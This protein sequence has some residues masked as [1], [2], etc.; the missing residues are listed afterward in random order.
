LVL[1]GQIEGLLPAGRSTLSLRLQSEFSFAVVVTTISV[2]AAD[3]PGCP[4]S[5]LRIAPAPVGQTIERRALIT[6]PI[7]VELVA[8]APPSC[9]DA[10]LPLRY[11]ATVR[12][13]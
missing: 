9:Q 11:V 10:M 13:T 7:A 5:V 3:A 6:V 1:S 8:S 2:T 4:G 12:K